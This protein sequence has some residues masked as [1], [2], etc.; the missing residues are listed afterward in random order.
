MLIGL[1]VAVQAPAYAPTNRC[2]LGHA[3]TDSVAILTLNGGGGWVLAEIGYSTTDPLYGMLRGRASQVGSWELFRLVC[4]DSV[5]GY[6][7]IQSF[8]NGRYVSAELGYART[9]A[10]YGMLRARATSVGPWE[11][12]RVLH[13]PG[14]DWNTVFQ[15]VANNDYVS[16]E[17]G[18]STDNPLYGMLRARATAIGPWEQYDLWWCPVS[19]TG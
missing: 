16:A 6:Y 11:K 13:T 3:D 4:V 8:V 18:Y 19:C 12:F 17:Y 10:H 7:A 2:D 15:S 1:L 9:D 5:N 14:I